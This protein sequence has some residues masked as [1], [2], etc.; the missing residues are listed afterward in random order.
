MREQCGYLT[1]KPR[2]CMV[3]PRGVG[4]L[5]SWRSIV[6]D[7]SLTINYQRLANQ[8]STHGVDEGSDAGDGNSNLIAEGE[9]E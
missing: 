2:P 6:N 3:R 8:P 4:D 5:T 9:S 1:K 7:R